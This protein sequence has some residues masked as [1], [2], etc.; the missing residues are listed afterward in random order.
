MPDFPRRVYL[1]GPMGSGKSTVGPLLADA[2]GTRFVDLDWLVEARTGRS[3]ASLFAIAGER[4]FRVAEAG[5]LAETTRGEPA[6]VATGGGTLAIPGNLRAARAAGA[7]VWLRAAPETLAARL[8][9]TDLT[10]RPLLAGP[11]GR[12]LAG[13]ALLTRLRSLID[14][15][16]PF[17]AQADVV[18]DAD[19]APEAVARTA[20]EALRGWQR[21]GLSDD[22]GYHP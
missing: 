11:D 20:A 19:G 13:S 12:P 14:A 22:A 18:V 21:E 16:E 17:Y 2:L 15:R 3:V 8:A 9:A 1:T 10:A 6:V 5:A 4:A 7:V